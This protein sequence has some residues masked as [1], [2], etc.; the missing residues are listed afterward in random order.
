ML[1]ALADSMAPNVHG[2]VPNAPI[3]AEVERALADGRAPSVKDLADWIGM[4]ESTLRC[5]LGYKPAGS[6]PRFQS[7]MLLD[8]AAKVLCA[9]DVLPAEVGL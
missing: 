3:R 9:I 1:T 4:N 8:T 6:R 7:R 2:A 5:A